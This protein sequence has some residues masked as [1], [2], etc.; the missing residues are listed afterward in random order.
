MN[1]EGDFSFNFNRV[2]TYNRAK[3]VYESKISLRLLSDQIVDS[4]TA[5]ERFPMR[6]FA[7]SRSDSRA[8]RALVPADKHRSSTTRGS[9]IAQRGENALKE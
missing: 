4:Y 7:R 2:G 8:S 5:A 9:V 3:N 1:E 6:C